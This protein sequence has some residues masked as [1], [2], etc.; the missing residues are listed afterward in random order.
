MKNTFTL[1]T[2]LLSVVSMS[3]QVT[4][5]EPMFENRYGHTLTKIE[6]GVAI[7]IGGSDGNNLQ[8]TAEYY[9]FVLDQWEYTG[10]MTSPRIDHTAD[11]IADDTVIVIGGYDGETNLAQTEIYDHITHTFS[12]GPVLPEGISYHRT[13]LIDNDGNATDYLLVTGGFNGNGYTAQCTLLNLTTMEFEAADSMHY[14][15]G[16]H[17][18]N[19][20]SDGRV[21]VTGGY[22]PDYGFQMN[23]CEIYDPATNEWT[24]VAPLNQPRDNHAAVALEDGSVWVS[25]GRYFNGNLNL[26]EGL[27]SCEKYDVTENDWS[28]DAST[29]GGHSYHQMIVY[30]DYLGLYFVLIPGST[31][32]SGIDVETTYSG[33]EWNILSVFGSDEYVQHDGT[34]RYRYGACLFYV[35]CV[36]VT[37]GLDGDASTADLYCPPNAV[38]ELLPDQ[39]MLLYPNPA[40]FFVSILNP[41]KPGAAYRITGLDG[42]LVAKGKLNISGK[43]I[44]TNLI[45]PGV[46]C[47]HVG[48][49][50]ARFVVQH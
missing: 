37:G 38:E 20:L 2:T 48:E 10:E 36:L 3:G 25:G 27:T 5:V 39:E 30:S 12:P 22:N 35:N 41:V 8:S 4:E 34:P 18:C 16:S 45:A 43:S 1:C 6:D 19:V 28:D 40:D 32:H 7:A 42:R 13:A 44:E 23:Q 21:L 29:V 33:S 50:V 9:S 49:A 17:T 46:Y 31:N 11:L 15:R 24:E 26:F 14:A 47:L